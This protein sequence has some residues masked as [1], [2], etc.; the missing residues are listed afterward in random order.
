MSTT[1][2]VQ[3]ARKTRLCQFASKCKFGS[4]CKFAHSTEELH[5]PPCWFFNNGG[6]RNETCKFSHIVVNGLRKPLQIQRPCRYQN[7]CTNQE[8]V[9]DHFELTEIEWKYHF[10]GIRYP[11]VGYYTQKPEKKLQVKVSFQTSNNDDYT[12]GDVKQKTIDNVDFPVFGKKNTNTNSVN[13]V[14]QKQIP[15]AVKGISQEKLVQK[16]EQV[17]ESHVQVLP[18]PI[19][20]AI[21]DSETYKYDIKKGLTWADDIEM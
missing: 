2:F 13:S 16:T 6:C 14:W 20:Q 9:F 10:I 4:H 1:T 5:K 7:Q 15:A 21:L 11:G 12:F 18:P 17:L 19:L 3:N 8:C